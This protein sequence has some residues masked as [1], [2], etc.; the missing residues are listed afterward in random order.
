M[1]NH[2][3]ALMRFSSESSHRYLLCDLPVRPLDWLLLPVP[4]LDPVVLAGSLARVFG[5]AVRT[6]LNRNAQ[7]PKLQ[8]G[9]INTIHFH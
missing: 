5:F 2:F 4:Y 9:L 1:A 6:L 7:I 3:N 8:K